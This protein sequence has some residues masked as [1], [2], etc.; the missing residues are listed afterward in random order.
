MLPSSLLISFSP[1]FSVLHMS[2]PGVGLYFIFNRRITMFAVICTFLNLPHLLMCFFGDSFAHAE[3]DPL[4]LLTFAAG[5]HRYAGWLALC[6]SN[7]DMKIVSTVRRP[8]ENTKMPI[9]A[10]TLAL[11]PRN[12]IFS[13]R[14]HGDRRRTFQRRLHRLQGRSLF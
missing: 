3:M 10:K 12:K 6:S 14:L 4:R 9:E 11:Q 5:N 7:P 1:L 2:L 8:Y 13:L